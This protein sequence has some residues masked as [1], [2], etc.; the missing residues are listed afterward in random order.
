MRYRVS[1]DAERDL[2]Q[3]F[4]YWAK[5]VSVETADRLIERITERFRLLGE[6]PDAGKLCTGIA[7]RVRCFPAGRY[8]I[9]YQAAR[10]VAN[11]L[12]I[13]H[14]ARD[15]KSAFNQR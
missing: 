13:F 10:P 12:H 4:L 14:S 7:P 15:Q 5:R 3:I 2:D 6:Y 8:L 11:I 1:A 9:Y